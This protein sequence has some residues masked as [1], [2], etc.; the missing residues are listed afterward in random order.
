MI[1]LELLESLLFQWINKRYNTIEYLIPNPLVATF[2]RLLITFANSLHTDQS[3][4]NVCS[5]LDPKY[6]EEFV[7]RSI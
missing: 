2:F 4:Q 6:F 5:G 7:K 1:M 3:E